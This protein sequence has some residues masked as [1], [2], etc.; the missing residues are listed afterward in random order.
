MNIENHDKHIEQLLKNAF[1]LEHELNQRLQVSGND[2]VNR[3]KIEMDLDYI[4]RHIKQLEEELETINSVKSIEKGY[5]TPTFFYAT[6]RSGKVK[7]TLKETGIKRSF[8]ENSSSETIRNKQSSATYNEKKIIRCVLA[9]NKRGVSLLDAINSIGL[10]DIEN[11]N[12]AEHN[13]PLGQIYEEAKQEIVI[14]GITAHTT[15][16]QHIEFLHGALKAGKRIYVLIIHPESPDIDDLSNR[17]SIDIRAHI[18]MVIDIAERER[19][20]EYEGF[21]LRFMKKPPPFTA[22]MIDGDVAYTG[23]KPN[24]QRGQIRVQ[25]GT[26][27]NPQHKGVILQFKKITGSLGGFDYFAADIRKQ[28]QNRINL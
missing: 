5:S 26:A 22:V 10:V 18:N 27:Y 24:D 19:L 17:D 25:P 6:Q 14:T 23:K 21:Q 4:K 7:E 1:D 9:K 3:R 12:E 13:L 16:I 8:D 2:P 11:R 20:I 15:F 28:W